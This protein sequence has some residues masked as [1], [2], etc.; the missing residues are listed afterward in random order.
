[1]YKIW[2]KDR[3]Y[4]FEIEEEGYVFNFPDEYE[5]YCDNQ[6]REEFQTQFE[7]VAIFYLNILENLHPNTKYEIKRI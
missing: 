3:D 6:E 1:M 4:D 7:N 2:Y 5:D